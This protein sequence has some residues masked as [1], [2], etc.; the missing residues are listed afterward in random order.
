[1]NMQFIAKFECL[2]YFFRHGFSGFVSI[3]SNCVILSLLYKERQILGIVL[4]APSERPMKVESG[5]F[6]GQAK[7]KSEAWLAGR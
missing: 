3:I 7:L 4:I 1:M 6:V 2:S 5:F